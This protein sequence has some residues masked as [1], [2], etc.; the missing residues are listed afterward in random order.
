MIVA[1]RH[2]YPLLLAKAAREAGVK[3]I[4]A[5]AFRGETRR[6]I[7]SLADEVVWNTLGQFRTLLERMKATGIRRTIL[8]GQIT[9]SN[10]FRLRPDALARELLRDVSIRNAHTIYGKAIEQFERIGLEVLPANSFMERHVPEEGVLSRRQ[11]SAREAADVEL[12]LRLV[13]G[14]SEFEIGQT[15]VVKEGVIV[16]V[17]AF[18]GTN[19]TIRRAGRVGGPGGVAVKVPK[20]GHDMRIDIPV[21]GTQTFSVMRRAR[22]ACL[23]VE[24]GKTI[25]LERDRLIALADRL[26]MA[27]LAV[28]APNET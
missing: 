28:K 19:R 3:R 21:V 8:A 16:A 26:G 23:A 13:K 20:A 17:E 10:L 6:A 14:T 22:I 7:A 27:F 11:P 5:M 24:A 2:A 18:E 12:G 1:G 4:V 25:L 15:V 9:P